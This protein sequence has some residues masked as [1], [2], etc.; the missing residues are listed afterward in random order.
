MTKLCVCETVV[1]D[2]VVCVT[3][4][5]VTKLCVKELCVTKL[6]VT[7]MCVREKLHVKEMCERLCVTKL[8]VGVTRS[9]MREVDAAG[10]HQAPRLPRKGT[11]M[12]PSATPA[13]QTES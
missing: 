5:S 7:K 12:S 11:L 10:C 8:C 1:C 9:C 6:C 3:K 13:T 4:L 2:K